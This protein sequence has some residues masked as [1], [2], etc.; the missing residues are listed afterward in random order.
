MS[1]G[2]PYFSWSI[3]TK[4]VKN[5]QKDHKVHQAANGHKLYQMAVKYTIIFHSEALQD[6]RIGIFGLKINHLGTLV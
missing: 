4:T 2:L 1:A 5:I 3:F 6:T